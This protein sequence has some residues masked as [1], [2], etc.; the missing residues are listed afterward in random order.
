M[1]HTSAEH[2]LILTYSSWQLMQPVI[3]RDCEELPEFHWVVGGGG[4]GGGGAG[5]FP[6]HPQVPSPLK[7]ELPSPPP[8]HIGRNVNNVTNEGKRAAL[9]TRSGGVSIGHLPL[10]T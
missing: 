7:D 3:Y 2:V 10:C 8:K 6:P 4:G 5:E 1:F 9:V